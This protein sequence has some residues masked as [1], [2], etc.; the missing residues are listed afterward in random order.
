MRKRVGRN[1][2]RSKTKQDDLELAQEARLHLSGLKFNPDA[3]CSVTM[4]PFCGVIWEDENFEDALSLP[5]LAKQ[6]IIALLATRSR[7]WGKIPLDRH[8]R[9]FWRYCRREFP[10]CPV[11]KRIKATPKILH[12][13]QSAVEGQAAFFEGW[14]VEG[15]D[16]E[17]G[18]QHFVRHPKDIPDES[19]PPKPPEAD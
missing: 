5:W 2:R 1:H 19:L 11:F 6:Q 16:E 12:N 9:Q 14:E 10:Q 13:L 3:E 4:L 7:I 17:T 15:E 8:E 18:A